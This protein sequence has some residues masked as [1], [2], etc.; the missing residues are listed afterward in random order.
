MLKSVLERVKRPVNI[1]S[2]IDNVPLHGISGFQIYYLDDFAPR[3][4][5]IATLPFECQSAAGENGPRMLH[6]KEIGKL[7][8]IGAVMD[9]EIRPLPRFQ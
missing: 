9:H 2:V 8:V 5:A 6:T 1:I 7:P 3:P 4:V